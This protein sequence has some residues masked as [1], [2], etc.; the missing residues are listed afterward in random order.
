MDQICL[1]NLVFYAYHGV[2]PEEARL[3]QRF[4]VDLVVTTDLRR[5]AAT[6]SLED[7]VSYAEL[8]EVVRQRATGQRF[9]LL[10][11]LGGAIAGDVLSGFPTVATASVT[12]RK[13]AVPIPGPL[14]C[15]A[16]TVNRHRD[17]QP[18]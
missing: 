17:A 7:T 10:E 13:P 5:A 14:D 18:G 6:D 8:Y 12:I 11:A 15:V 16:V 3:G 1:R 4:E 9:N 2:H